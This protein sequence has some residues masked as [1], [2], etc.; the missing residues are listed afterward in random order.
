[1]P[2]Y[3]LKDKPGYRVEVS[4]TDSFGKHKKIV[5]QNKQTITMKG[6][7]QTEVDILQSLKIDKGDKNITFNDLLKYYEETKQ[8]EVRKIT[9]QKN[10]RVLKSYMLDQFGDRKVN[11][12]TKQDFQKWKNEINKHDF[13]TSY[14]NALYSLFVN[15]INFGVKYDYIEIN[16]LAKL[17]NFKNIDAIEETN[18][19]FWT[20]EEFNKFIKN[21]REKCIEL[22]TAGDGDYLVHWGY[23]VIYNIMYWCGLRKSEAY[24]L[25]W[26]DYYNNEL[27]ITKGIVHKLKGE[28]Y[29]INRPKTKGSIRNSSVPNQ[30]IKVLE[31]QKERY[32]N[33]YLFGGDFYIC[34]GVTPLTDTKLCE[35]KNTCAEEAGVKKIRIHD[36]RHS[37][38][39]LL[40]NKGINAQVVAKRLGHTDIKMTLNTYSHL[41][42]KTEDEALDLINS[43]E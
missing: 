28:G 18:V 2:I 4:Y 1:M 20:L 23:Y 35:F 16:N 8:Y 5:K 12:V 21:V 26:K 9:L 13:K 38:A 41:F 32:R 33:V 6:A 11:S 25:Q 14:K 36:F 29:V 22:E 30:L 37:H 15:F 10:I 3:K 34:G 43:L 17:G 7:K 19:D 42:Q 24:A 39:S 40:I 27:H 31:E